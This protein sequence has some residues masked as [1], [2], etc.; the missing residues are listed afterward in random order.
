[1]QKVKYDDCVVSTEVQDLDIAV[2]EKATVSKKQKTLEMLLGVQR[3]LH[4]T[5]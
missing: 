3:V 5:L 2:K 4:L 1:M